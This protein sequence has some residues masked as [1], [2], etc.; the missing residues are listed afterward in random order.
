[1]VEAS[2]PLP[3]PEC[4]GL[5]E[6]LETPWTRELL[7]DC[8]KWTAYL[9]NSIDGG[10]PTAAALVL[11][12]RFNARCVT[13]TNSPPKGPGQ[14]STQLWL[15]GPDGDLPLMYV[16]ERVEN[17]LRLWHN[18]LRRGTKT[19]FLNL[20]VTRAFPIC[21]PA[22]EEQPEIVNRIEGMS[23][24]C[25]HATRPIDPRESVPRRV[26]PQDPSDEPASELLAP[27]RTTR[28]AAEAS[29]KAE[30]QGKIDLSVGRS[31]C[32]VSVRP[33][34]QESS[35]PTSRPPRSP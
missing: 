8:G 20:T 29:K 1:M 32:M 7:I 12:K 19:G 4:F 18:R 21:I 17:A 31:F 27:I 16:A 2:E 11:V 14:A 24:I 22:I 34:S 5:L 3:Y 9:N 28:E 25:P 10:D 33:E 30:K 35:W 6:P 13:A 23:K 26:G 15:Q